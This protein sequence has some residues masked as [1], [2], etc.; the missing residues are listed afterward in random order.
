MAFNEKRFERYAMQAELESQKA[1][2]E[3][4]PAGGISVDAVGAALGYSVAES[5][6]LA[7]QLHREGWAHVEFTTAPYLTLNIKGH[8]EIAKLH[9]PQWRRWLHVNKATVIATASLIISAILLV[10]RLLGK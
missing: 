4:N 9:W 7:L 2:F 10:L 3:S 6:Q 5:R 1:S 8:R